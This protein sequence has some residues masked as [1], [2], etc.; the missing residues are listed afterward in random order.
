MRQRALDALIEEM[1]QLVMRQA[2]EVPEPLRRRAE[3]VL[4]SVHGKS[5]RWLDDIAAPTSLLD[6][7]FVAEGRLRQQYYLGLDIDFEDF[8]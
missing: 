2:H 3:H 8:G 7:L 4:A 5:P 6:H 1:E